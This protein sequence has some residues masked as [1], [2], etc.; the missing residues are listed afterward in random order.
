MPPTATDTFTKELD[1]IGARYES[2]FA[3]QS[4]AT[5]NLDEIDA[6]IKETANLV[7]RIKS[8]PS[9]AA[10]KGIAG[11]AKSAEDALAMYKNERELIVQAKN[12]PPEAETFAPLAAG[13]NLAFSRY[14][15][16]FAG[17]SRP[18]RDTGLL[19]ELI[20]D[21]EGISEGME[22]IVAA[23]KSKPFAQDLE[24]V[25]S[26]VAMYTTERKAIIDSRATGTLD[27][28]GSNLASRANAQFNLYQAH[29]AG[30]S[31]A[32]RR[33]ALLGRMVEELTAVRAEMQALA[34]AGLKQGSNSANIGIVD[35]QLAMYKAELAEVRKARQ[36]A[37]LADLMGMLGGAA[38]DAMAEYRENF[39]GHDRNTRDLA[40]LTKICDELAEIRRQMADL[41]RAEASS[42]NDRNL[43]IVSSQLALF[44]REYELIE[45]AKKS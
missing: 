17:Q 16:H 12:A 1:T 37:P 38:N 40:L 30:K 10:P 41:G 19:D 44:E 23:T 29:F 42:V 5:R 8:I 13:A 25:R 39:A 7:A 9:A 45:V 20:G 22:E 15:R 6:I 31:R 18:T 28:R 14:H 24:L 2:Q 27:E 35:K 34:D 32:T 21:L 26:T 11:V 36:G 3:G 33:P 4:R 43:E